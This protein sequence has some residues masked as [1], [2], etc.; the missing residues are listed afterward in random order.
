MLWEA[1]VRCNYDILQ[2][3]TDMKVSGKTD[4]LQGLEGK[5]PS[6]KRVHTDWLSLFGNAFEIIALCLK[7]RHLSA[8]TLLEI[9]KKQ[10]KEMKQHPGPLKCHHFFPTNF[11]RAFGQV[12]RKGYRVI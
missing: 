9:D 7:Y 1:E 12:H 6:S 5:D 8:L 4:G 11:Q 2:M 3:P 10:P